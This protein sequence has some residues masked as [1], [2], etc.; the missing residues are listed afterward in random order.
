MTPIVLPILPA[1]ATPATSPTGPT[2]G[3]GLSFLGTISDALMRVS[4]AQKAA[5]ISEQNVA[6]GK[7]GASQATA[8]ILSDRAE[9]GM[10]GIVATRNEIVSAYQTLTNMQI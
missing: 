3:G 10:N 5:S 1:L 9:I 6:A 7:P 2:T 8:L 4:E